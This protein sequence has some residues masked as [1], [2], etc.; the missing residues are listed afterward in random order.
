[1]QCIR[2]KHVVPVRFKKLFNSTCPICGRGLGYSVEDLLEDPDTGLINKP[3]PTQLQIAKKI[4]AALEA[5]VPRTLFIKAGCGIGKTYAY[6]IPAL[7]SGKRFVISTENKALQEQ[8]SDKDLPAVCSV[9]GKRSVVCLKGRTNYLCRKKLVQHKELFI[10]KGKED[11]HTKLT[12]WIETHP[13]GEHRHFAPMLYF[14]ATL[15]QADECTAVRCTHHKDCGYHKLKQDVKDADVIITN[16]AMLGLVLKLSDMVGKPV[17]FGPYTTLIVD[18]AH[19]CV[20]SFRNAFSKTVSSK[21][22]NSFFDQLKHEDIYYNKEASEERLETWQAL[23]DNIKPPL[24]LANSTTALEPG[25]FGEAVQDALDLIDQL[26]FEI[27]STLGK[28]WPQYTP[29]DYLQHPF[30]ETCEDIITDLETK[31]Y[32]LKQNP[33]EMLRL[34]DLSTRDVLDAEDALFDGVDTS[35]S[36]GVKIV[37]QRINKEIDAVGTLQKKWEKINEKRDILKMSRQEK[38]NVAYEGYT[39]SSGLTIVKQIPVDVKPFVAPPLKRIPN[40]VFC[41]GTLHFSLFTKEI[42]ITSDIAIV[43]PTPFDCVSNARLYIPKH[44]PHPKRATSEEYYDGTMQETVRLLRLS[45]GNAFVL[46]TSYEALDA[47]YNVI[48]NQYNLEY[49]TIVQKKGMPASV[50]E[51]RFR[52]TE[53]AVLFG[54]RS[55]YSGI[56]VPGPKLRLIIVPKIPFESPVTALNIARAAIIGKGFFP[57][58]CLPT[59]YSLMEQIAGRL[60]RTSTDQGV[61]AILD[62]RIWVSGDKYLNAPDVSEEQWKSINGY[63]YKLYQQLPYPNWSDNIQDVKTFF[64]SMGI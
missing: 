57:D 55:F 42:G 38:Q 4:Y 56:D 51:N 59:M 5:R 46:F 23:F 37:I 12:K 32:T 18:E 53:D 30:T 24:D 1:M 35:E 54:V 21:W 58:Y 20:E 64:K 61:L 31:R 63:G 34:T 29:S 49:P 50:A 47:S 14:P 16:H 60:L 41:S 15:C 36:N 7:V 25:F 11:Y 62:P 13:T 52:K 28:R 39:S 48:K 10:K 43:E 33:S 45:K 40:K 6:T 19:A 3:R 2:C 9:I 8:L 27:K 17:M 44:L 22:L 26:K